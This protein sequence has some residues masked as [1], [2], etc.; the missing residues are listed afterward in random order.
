MIASDPIKS[1]LKEL[2][3]RR[4]STYVFLLKYAI[5]VQF[6]H[7]TSG[8][9]R[10]SSNAIFHPLRRSLKIVPLLG[11]LPRQPRNWRDLSCTIIDPERALTG[12]NVCSVCAGENRIGNGPLAVA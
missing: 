10:L 6:G 9:W 8:L 5:G 12:R 4:P 2:A 7:K 3:S 11:Y 1:L